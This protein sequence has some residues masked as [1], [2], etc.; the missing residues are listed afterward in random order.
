M[1]L[2]RARVR[3]G[4]AAAA[5]AVMAGL[6]AAS[7]GSANAARLTSVRG[8]AAPAAGLAVY[9]LK[10][11]WGACAHGI[12][13]PFQCAAEPVPLD[14]RHPAGSK[15]SIA[16]MRLPAA[17]PKSRIGSLFINF[18]GPGGPGITDLINRAYT[19]FS[20]AIRARFDLVA[21][22][23]RGIEYS[24]PVN[25]FASD[26]ASQN[27]FNSVPVFPYPQ[28]G[29]PGFF[30]LNAQLGTDCAQRS[31]TLLRHVSTTDTARDLDLL[32]QDVGDKKLTY[33]GFSYGT[34][35]GATYANLFPRNVR[36]M[37]LD[38]TL[39]FVGNVTGV[40]PGDAAKYP[41]DVRQ[42]VDRAGQDVFGRFLTLCAQAGSNCAFSA[43]SG[44]PGPQAKWAALL[45][46][47]QAGH[48]SYQDLMTFAY[49]DM[50]KPIADWPGLASYL[51][52]LY[53]TTAAGHALNARQAAG[54]AAAAS[55]AASESLIRPA[56]SQSPAQATSNP[57]NACAAASTPYTDNGSDAYYAIQCAD[58]LVPTKTSVYH[59]L[60]NSE[61]TKVPGFGRLIVYDTMPCATWPAMHTDA[62]D[63]PWNRS[64]ATILVINAL[65]DPFTPIWGARAAVTEL[66]NAQLLTV[67]G[68]GHTSMY[69]EPST[70]RD[71]AE[72]TYLVSGKLPAKGAIC[73]VN[74]L[75]FGL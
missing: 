33:L 41:I 21:W 16:L 25:C 14:Y 44:G 66:R 74:A 75:P 32:R 64:A 65:H 3:A 51:Q 53:V 67:N 1:N 61:D 4:S 28:S 49:Y 9:R 31:G 12:P 58:S 69:V 59:N 46:R 18:G 36:A 7:S 11:T 6:F 71:S 24:A 60:A 68:D 13:Q 8:V 45:S 47:A 2:A 62:Y 52:N 73:Q 72:L 22:D 30:T 23:P 50:E 20:A 63:G 56:A 38:G 10:V 17:D 54:L 42:G 26:T 19:V 40:H 55:R 15:I 43:A 70:C 34:V 39:D 27:Y 5:L 37:V 48:L 35:I 29:E 57:A